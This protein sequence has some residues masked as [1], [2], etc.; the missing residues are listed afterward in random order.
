MFP[1]EIPTQGLD[2]VLEPKLLTWREATVVKYLSIKRGREE[3]S[4]T[5]IDCAVELEIQGILAFIAFMAIGIILA[6]I[7]QTLETSLIIDEW[8]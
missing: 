5:E 2:F 6:W 3:A 8:A 7:V 1:I 4:E